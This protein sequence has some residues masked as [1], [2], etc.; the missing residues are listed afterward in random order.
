MT[1]Q[2]HAFGVLCGMV[3]FEMVEEV[4]GVSHS[5][6]HW[7]STILSSLQFCRLCQCHRP[8]FHR[9]DRSFWSC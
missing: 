5:A 6:E 2:T 4:G 1:A 3:P 9:S 8:R 7:S